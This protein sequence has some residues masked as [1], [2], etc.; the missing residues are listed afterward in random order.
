ML[1]E[2]LCCD[3]L[4]YVGVVVLME[5]LCECMLLMLLVLLFIVD[6]LGVLCVGGCV[7]LLGLELLVDDIV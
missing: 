4:C 6:W 7:L 5:C 3:D 1:I 2:F